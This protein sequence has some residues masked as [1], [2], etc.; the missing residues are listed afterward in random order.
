M[1]TEVSQELIVE[2]ND[3]LVSGDTEEVTAIAGDLKQNLEKISHHGKRADSLSI[4]YDVVVKVS[5]RIRK[6]WD[7][8][9]LAKRYPLF[10][11]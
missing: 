9:I 8:H 7:S 1:G 5:C 11:G 2:L 4:N 6:S 3:Y 10:A